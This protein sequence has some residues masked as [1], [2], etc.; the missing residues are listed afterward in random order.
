[1]R[2]APPPRAVPRRPARALLATASAGLLTAALT[3]IA[4]AA[5]DPAPGPVPGPV[6]GPVPG[7]VL[8]PVPGPVLGPVPGT[9]TGP[10]GQK[11]TVTN[12]KDLKPAGETVTV[13]G[14][15]Y[16]LDKGIYLAVCVLGKEGEAPSPCLG[17]ADLS[18]RSGSSYWISNNPPDY[19]KDI[20]K[21]F[22]EQP[23]GKGGFTFDLTARIKDGGADCTRLRCAIVT[24]ADHTHNSD[25]D[26]DVIVPITFGE[27][28][29]ETPEVPAGTVRHT[30][31]RA[32]A[33]TEGG[34]TDAEVDPANGRLYV[35]R[36]DGT[37]SRLTT[38][39]S[40]TGLPVGTPVTLPSRSQVMALDPA[41][42]T[43]YLA[44]ADRIGAYDTR[45][46]R[47]TADWAAVTGNV[48]H[49][50]LDPGAG[51]LYVGNQTAK[52]VMVYDTASGKPVGEPVVL[53]VF[54][55][56]LAVDTNSHTGYA[57]HVTSVRENGQTVFRN[58]L[59][60]VDGA[61]GRATTTLNLGTTALGSMGVTVD[62]ATGTGYVANLA[63][64]S[65]F[66]VD[67]RANQVTGTLEV[68]GNPKTMVHDAGTSTLYVAQTTA[69]AVAAV[70][71]RTGRV[72]ETFPTGNQ[73]G[74]LALHPKNHTVFAVASGTV[75]QTARQTAAT[76][77]THPA[78]LTVDEG[79]QATF[80]AAATGSP[81]PTVTWESSADEG[82][83][84][85][86]VENATGPTLAFTPTKEQT[87][88]LFRASF[89]NPVGTVR[90]SAAPL[91]VTPKQTN[92]DPTDP[93]TGD[94]SDPD[95]G[96]GDP[97]DPGTGDPTDPTDPTA[98][99][100]PGTG[101][102]S[103]PGTGDPSDPSDP[104]GPADPSAPGTSGG[105]SVSGGDGSTGSGT[106]SGTAGSTAGDTAGVPG[107]SSTVGGNTAGTVG[108]GGTA[109]GVDSGTGTGPLASTGSP[110]MALG[111]TAAALTALGTFTLVVRRR[112]RRTTA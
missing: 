103:D 64:G 76:P 42:G 63:A 47:L 38:Y 13:T 10:T 48:N 28:P 95:P 92:P 57:T 3:G 1:M 60:G 44:L 91:A 98:P 82:K 77:T 15:G 45:T 100:D 50:A 107:A 24:R 25:R 80:T 70:D 41:T 81:E 43:L 30:T 61:T 73:P 34:A 26:Q 105:G 89:T 2:S 9:A 32:Y 79:K 53:P 16:A 37:A 12:T 8:G 17:G 46:G 65:V 72:T 29:G 94:P 18:G 59:T 86:P 54:P 4:P 83:T 14:S 35:S 85:K 11:L 33:A 55:A 21:K 7:P 109:G 49:L 78:P 108:G 56:G 97:S 62:P 39:D 101:D 93:G 36:S 51:R 31:V 40:T 90:T 111:A 88:H 22:T 71:L 99:S 6:L 110:A 20:V 27:G 52:S 74:A 69:G 96:T 84:W 66:T 67:L 23:D 19:A 5:D 104:A 87:G 112:S 58:I 102:P 68:G 75:T 106:G